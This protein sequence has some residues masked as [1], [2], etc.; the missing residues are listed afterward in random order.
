[1]ERTDH[2][3]TREIL[4]VNCLPVAA[5]RG[6]EIYKSQD[7]APTLDEINLRLGAESL[8]AVSLRTYRHY[9]R[10]FANHF[11]DY[12]PINELDVR[13]KLSRA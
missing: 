11:A 9:R 6:W 10:L 12:M 8:G 3:D 13:L 7:P 5:K 1:M 2:T 4:N